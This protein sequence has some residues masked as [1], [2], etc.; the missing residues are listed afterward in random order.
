MNII[1]ISFR[2]CIIDGQF[3]F[4]LSF[5]WLVKPKPI[6]KIDKSNKL[7]K[8]QSNRER[9]K[10][11]DKG[12]LKN[13]SDLARCYSFLPGLQGQLIWVTYPRHTLSLG[14]CDLKWLTAARIIPGYM[15]VV[16]G[17]LEHTSLDCSGA[18]W[19]TF[20]LSTILTKT[21][22]PAAWLAPEFWEKGQKLTNMVKFTIAR[23][24]FMI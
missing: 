12:K 16:T 24:F 11:Q 10:K 9:E 22:T 23:V 17:D 20:C 19:A 4:F 15:L 3:R 2:A 21:W 6:D 18:V 1:Q 5:D 7:L 14:P 13:S 8:N